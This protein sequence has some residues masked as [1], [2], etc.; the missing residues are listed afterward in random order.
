MNKKVLL[1]WIFAISALITNA[2][3]GEQG[4][5]TSAKKT[6]D[7]LLINEYNINGVVITA[8]KRSMKQINVPAAIT[9]V[10][11]TKIERDRIESV[12]DL[13]ARIP[14][15]FMPQYGSKL[16][17]PVYIR[18]IGSRINSPSIGL[19]VDNVAYFEKSAFDIDLYDVKRIEVLRGPQGTLYGRNTMG[20]IIN[21]ITRD[22]GNISSTRLYAGTGNYGTQQYKFGHAEPLIKNKLFLSVDGN[23]RSKNGYY[24]NEFFNKS[25][26]P[27]HSGGGRIKLDF[28]PSKTF[29]LQF[30]SGGEIS[31][32]GGYPYG[33]MTDQGSLPVLSYDHKSTYDR[34]MLNNSL[35]LEKNFNGFNLISVTGLQLMKDNQDIDQDFTPADL[36]VVKQDQDQ[37]LLTQEFNISSKEGKSLQWIGGFYGFYQKMDRVVDVAYG[38]DGVVKYHLPGAMSLEKTY[39]MDNQGAAVFGQA[40]YND[41]LIN[42]LDITA[43]L[44]YDLEKDKLDY[45][46]DRTVLGNTS[47]ADKFNHSL[48][49]NELMPKFAL[50]YHWGQN[51]MQYASISRGYK[52]GG[53]NST[54]ERPE[55]ES[56]DSEYSW[57]YET[58]LKSDFLH[59]QL[60]ATL[61]FFYI[62]WT[63]QQ[64]YQ[65][66]PSGKGSMLKNA[67][68]SK[69]LGFETEI[70]ARPVKNL[71]TSFAMGYTAA[72]FVNYS[73]NATTDYSGN[74]IPYVPRYTYSLDATYRI[75]FAGSMMQSLVIN[76]SCNGVGKIYWDEENQLAQNPYGL[77]SARISMDFGYV[78]FA[79][80]SKNM[81][82]QQY[83]SFQFSALGNNYAQP[84]IPRTY[85]MSVSAKF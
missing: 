14:N 47:N 72:T 52:S 65:T 31:N 66:V 26:D 58:G 15:L 64:V 12:R 62:D 59:N 68:K 27:M 17:A 24:T 32:E 4:N 56:F 23:Y 61:A 73:E 80:W 38:A 3:S 5:R 83:T 16:T 18:G 1:I 46:Y 33:I 48:S 53:F 13:S 84:G 36:L 49:F 30:L 37:N 67:G 79:V 19:Y 74:Y 28:K 41:L 76:G 60:T 69:S 54:I 9:S 42:G 78:G 43:G 35:R 25:L 20:G 57:N 85:G 2:Q 34:K 82:D 22:P 50:K 21:I 71:I 11:A 29:S 63:N 70:S 75:P 45:N 6:P 10:S 51:I 8:E 44:R 77:L 39:L 40:T 7:T 81:L 55:D